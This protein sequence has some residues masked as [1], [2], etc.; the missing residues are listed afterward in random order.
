MV[1]VVV[2]TEANGACDTLYD[3]NEVTTTN[4]KALISAK[5]IRPLP[6]ES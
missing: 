1:V 6:R 2:D 3:T 5:K 4:N